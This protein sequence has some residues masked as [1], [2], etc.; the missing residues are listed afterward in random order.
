LIE[1]LKAALPLAVATAAHAVVVAH[2]VMAVTDTLMAVMT[3]AVE[4]VLSSAGTTRM[5]TATTPGVRRL[6]GLAPGAVVVS[7]PGRIGI[8]VPSSRMYNV[9]PAN[10]WAMW[11][12][13]VTCWQPP[14]I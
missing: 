13:T 10:G 4:M 9:P 8:A 3:L 11:Q 7:S 14:F 6:T 12:S 1:P 5:A 2:F